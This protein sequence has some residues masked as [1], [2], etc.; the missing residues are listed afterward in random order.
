M[1]K[2]SDRIGQFITIPVTVVKMF[3]LLSPEAVKIFVYLRFKTN[4]KTDT[5]FPSYDSIQKDTKMSRRKIARAIRELMTVGLV[6]RRRRFSS[7][8]IYTLVLPKRISSTVAT[9]DSSTVATNDSSDGD[10]LSRMTILERKDKNKTIGASA[11]NGKKPHPRNP[12]FDALADV[13]HLDP[14]V[15]GSRIGKTS[16]KLGDYQPDDVRRWYSPGGWWYAVRCK[17]LAAAPPPSPEGIEKTILLA[18][19]SD[20]PKVTVI[21]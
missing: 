6:E 3:P 4:S 12:M 17:G 9:N 13:C 8:T 19:E 2:L 21:R 20:I 5:A 10:T 18:S 7:S 15:M 11:P 16:A 1:S 14:K